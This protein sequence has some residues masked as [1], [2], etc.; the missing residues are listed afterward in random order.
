MAINTLKA[1]IQMRRGMKEDLDTSQLVAGEWAVVLAN[2]P[3]ARDGKSVYICFT[4]GNVKRMATYEDMVDNIADITDEIRAIFIRD[5][6]EI[7]AAVEEL[8][9][10]I[11]GYKDIASEKAN[12]ATDAADTAT[13]KANESVSYAGISQ[14]Y[15]IGTENTVRENDETDN[16][17]YYSEQSKIN[18]DKAESARD[19]TEQSIHDAFNIMSGNFLMDLPTGHLMYNGSFADFIVQ[20]GHLKWGIVA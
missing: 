15:A 3:Y 14:S 10:E 18:A 1:T 7:K 13:S 5:F 12:I 20:N 6:N 16:S 2:D 4:A 8:R 19:E 17:K 11:K 9:D